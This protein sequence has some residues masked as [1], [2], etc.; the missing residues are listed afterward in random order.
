MRVQKIFK[1]LLILLNKLLQRNPQEE[2]KNPQFSVYSF[3][4]SDRILLSLANIPTVSNIL[5]QL[6][7]RNVQ[8]L[9]SAE[10]FSYISSV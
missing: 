7:Y 2:K 3:G 9:G 1:I 10:V 5:I 4:A 8:I 6:L